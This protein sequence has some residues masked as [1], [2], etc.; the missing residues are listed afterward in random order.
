MDKIKHNF[1]QVNGLKIHVAEIGSGTDRVV[2]VV[3]KD[4]SNRIAHVFAI[5]HP[6]RIAGFITF[7]VPAAPLNRPRLAEPLPGGAYTSRWMVVE[8][9]TPSTKSRVL[10]TEP[11]F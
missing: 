3:A 10:N 2:Y 7:G 4:F 8:R 6:K 5:L 1:I 11:K 9:K